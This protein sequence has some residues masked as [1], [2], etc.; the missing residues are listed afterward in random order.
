MGEGGG[1]QSF[2]DGLIF[3]A[4][5]AIAAFVALVVFYALAELV[6]VMVDIAINVR[7]LVKAHAP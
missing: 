5:M 4:A 2:V 6:I 3:L 7:R 1:G